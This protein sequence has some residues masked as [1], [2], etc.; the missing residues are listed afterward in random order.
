MSFAI[1]VFHI[2][3]IFTSWLSQVRSRLQL[4]SCLRPRRHVT[5]YFA[6]GVSCRNL[7]LS[8]YDSVS[9]TFFFLLFTQSSFLPQIFRALFGAS[10]RKL[11]TSCYSFWTQFFVGLYVSTDVWDINHSNHVGRFHFVRPV[12]FTGNVVGLSW[13]PHSLPRSD[14]SLYNTRVRIM[15]SEL[16]QPRL[17]CTKVPSGIWGLSPFVATQFPFADFPHLWFEITARVCW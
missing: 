15:F 13:S 10:V 14:I 12:T 9:P 4:Y 11:L 6:L 1:I 3:N 17:A 2:P 5:A 8:F 16:V 7:P